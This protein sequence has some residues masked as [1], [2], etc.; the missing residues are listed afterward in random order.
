MPQPPCGNVYKVRSQPFGSSQTP[1]FSGVGLAFLDEAGLR[2]TGKR[3][4]VLADGLGLAGVLL[5][6]L[7]E[8][9][10]GSASEW[11]AGLVHGFGLAGVVR[12]C[13][14]GSEGSFVLLSAEFIRMAFAR[15][16]ATRNQSCP[17][18]DR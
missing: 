14:P 10:Q 1:H 3:L 13:R 11:F 2:G 16:S 5:A 6:F 8:T 18:H 4:A 15:I 17:T 7:Q 12:H 9:G